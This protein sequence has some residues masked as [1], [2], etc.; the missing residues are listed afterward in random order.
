MSDLNGR[1]PKL[2]INTSCVTVWPNPS[3]VAVMQFTG[4]KD[5][6]GVEI[7]EGDVVRYVME[8][9]TYIGPVEFEDGM[10]LIQLDPT[11]QPFENDVPQQSEVIGNIYENQ[12]LIK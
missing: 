3:E 11:G 8:Y 4:L 12:E 6:D 2:E 1:T 9:G 7:Y 10:F 5:R